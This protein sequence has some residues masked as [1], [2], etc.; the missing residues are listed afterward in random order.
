[1]NLRGHNSIHNI[2]PSGLPK[3]MSFLCARHIHPI[4]TAPGITPIPASTLKSKVSSK[5]H[6][7]QVWV[8][9]NVWFILRQN[10]SPAVKLWNQTSY[11]ILNY[12]GVTGITERFPFQKG[13]TGKKKGMMGS[14][15]VQNLARQIPLDLKACYGLNVG[16]HLPSMPKFITLTL[17][18]G[19]LE[20]ASLGGTLG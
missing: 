13:E 18:W 1:M 14:K 10:C 11:L 16:S 19:Y 7:N 5:Y 4:P 20:M 9:L 12:S 6:L 15:Q 2:P 3:C 17:V 8:G